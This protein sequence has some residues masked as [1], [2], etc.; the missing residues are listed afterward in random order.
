MFQAQNRETINSTRKVAASFKIIMTTSV[1]SPCYTTQHQTCK[2]KT[3]F[4]VS[5]R[6]CPQTDVSAHITDYQLTLWWQKLVKNLFTFHTC[7]SVSVLCC[8]PRPMVGGGDTV[9][10]NVL[11]L[12]IGPD[13]MTDRKRILQGDQKHVPPPHCPDLT[14]FMAQFRMLKPFDL[15]QC[16]CTNMLLV[17][18]LAIRVLKLQIQNLGPMKNSEIVVSIVVGTRS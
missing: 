10:A 13:A 8:G 7:I 2:T 16:W 9:F 5:D 14:H 4:L 12:N 17:T 6:S 3:D 18:N 1:T 15:D 11:D